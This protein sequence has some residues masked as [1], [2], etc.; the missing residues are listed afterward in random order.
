MLEME[1]EELLQVFRAVYKDEAS[2][3]TTPL[4]KTLHIKPRFDSKSGEHIILW[5]DVK[6]VFRTLCILQPLRISAP[7]DVVLDVALESTGTEIG[8][9]S[10]SVQS[11]P[12]STLTLSTIL[13]SHSSAETVSA[14]SN[15]SPATIRDISQTQ[16]SSNFYNHI[17]PAIGEQHGNGAFTENYDDGDMNENYARGLAYYECKNIRHDY[18]DAQC[19][20]EYMYVNGYGVPHDYPKAL[21]LF[22]KSAEQGLARGQFCLGFLYYSGYCAIIDQSKAVEWYQK[23]TDQ[24]NANAI[25]NLSFMY[26]EGYG[27][28]KD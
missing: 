20:L 26:Q 28:V 11:S 12:T 15:S 5:N 4:T 10:L 8:I 24:G 14:A 18:A 17:V 3:S 16:Q 13:N 2:G 21:E 9:E 25:C 19:N 22:R 6:T 23:A 7:P 27:V 1:Q